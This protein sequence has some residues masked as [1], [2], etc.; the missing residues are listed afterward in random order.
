MS[1]DSRK[2]PA[3]VFA[4]IAGFAALMQKDEDLSITHLGRF[5]ETIKS[6]SPWRYDF[7]RS[8]FVFLLSLIC[9]SFHAQAVEITKVESEEINQFADSIRDIK[10]FSSKYIFVKL[11]EFEF[12]EEHAIRFNLYFLVKERS[13]FSMIT[14][15]SFWV[16]GA[17]R[18]PRNY[19]MSSD[20]EQLTFEHGSKQQP[21]TSVL[22]ISTSEIEVL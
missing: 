9:L 14:Q 15:N 10:T 2:L 13:N 17:F 19:Q 4:N 22:K 18:D 1:P 20:M 3:T 12:I 6:E 7:R 16:K 8:L 21:S 11:I 5:E